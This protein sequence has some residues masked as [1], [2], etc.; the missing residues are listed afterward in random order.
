[1]IFVVIGIV[2]MHTL[3]DNTRNW[4]PNGKTWSVPSRKTKSTIT[5]V[6]QYIG[7][8]LVIVKK[9]D[10]PYFLCCVGYLTY[11]FINVLCTC[12]IMLVNYY[13]YEGLVFYL[14]YVK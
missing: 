8:L 3:L 1:M 11:N 7:P 13:N 10:S 5:T 12:K 6:Q 2:M 14:F 4:N 9:A